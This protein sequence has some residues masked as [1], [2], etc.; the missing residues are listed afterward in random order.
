M[1]LSPVYKVILVAKTRFLPMALSSFLAL[2]TIATLE[3]PSMTPPAFA[4][5]GNASPQIIAH[6]GGRKWGPENTMAVFRKCVD[7]KIY[8]I[9]LD[10]HRCKSG[11]LVVIHD[12]ELARTTSGTGLVK[13]FNLEELRKLS[14]GKWFGKEFESE[15][16]PLLTE[17]L[18]LLDGKVYLNIEIKNAPIE[19][20]GIE[21]DLI[22]ILKSYK[23]TDQ[24]IVSSFD[25]QVLKKLHDK[26]PQYKLGFLDSAIPVKIDSYAKEVGASAWHPEFS[27]IRKDSVALAHA[28]GIKVNAWTINKE[29]DWKVAVDIGIDGIVTDD[30]EGLTMYLKS[31]SSR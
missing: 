30:P 13:D 16:I 7:N 20:P 15:K 10:I 9:E 3:N 14:A 17:V 12:C 24:I 5:A 1:A 4:S 2:A 26:A 25:H 18:D 22:K 19:Y 28:G 27:E 8:G 29:S 31:N 21:D 23:Y 11:E 6:R